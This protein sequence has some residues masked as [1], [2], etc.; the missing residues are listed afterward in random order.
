M[1]EPPRHQAPNFSL[2][3]FKDLFPLFAVYLMTVKQ[4]PDYV[5]KGSVARQLLYWVK[6]KYTATQHPLT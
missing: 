3:F 1:T 4:Q 5:L 6:E 2:S